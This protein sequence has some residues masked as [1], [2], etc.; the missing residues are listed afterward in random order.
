MGRNLLGTIF[1]AF[2]SADY[3]SLY[4]IHNKTLDPAS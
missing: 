2:L 1:F 4:T 3:A